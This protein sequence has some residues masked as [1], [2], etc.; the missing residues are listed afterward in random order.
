METATSTA[1]AALVVA[2]LAMFVAMVQALQ[3]YYVTGH[4]IRLCDSVVFGKMPGRGKRVWEMSQLR[5]RI[6]YSMPQ[7]SLHAHLWPDIA[8]HIPSYAKGTEPLPDLRMVDREDA[9]HSKERSY[10]TAVPGEAS[11]VSFCR[12]VQNSCGR[13]MVLEL[14]QGDADRC[15]SDLPNVP[16]PMSMRDIAAM[17]LMAGMKCT[18]ASFESKSLSMQGAIGTITTSQHPLLGPILHFAPRNLSGKAPRD[19]RLSDGAISPSWMART[20]GDAVVAG[21]H[22]SLSERRQVE[23]DEAAWLRRLRDM[24]VIPVNRH[25]S[26]PP[27]LIM[28][29][30]RR[31]FRRTKS[32]TGS[33]DQNS[34]TNPVPTSQAAKKSYCN[35][36]TT[37]WAHSDG[38]WYFENSPRDVTQHP[39]S[40]SDQV[41]QHFQSTQTASSSREAAYMDSLT[42]PFT[43][44]FRRRRKRNHVAT[45]DPFGIEIEGGRRQSEKTEIAHE[46][47]SQS[48]GKENLATSRTFTSG[49]VQ[50]APVPHGGLGLDRQPRWFIREYV[51]EKRQVRAERGNAENRGKRPLLIKWH[52]G[53]D[54]E[55]PDFNGA[56]VGVTQAVLDM[57]PRPTRQ[58]GEQRA[59]FYAHKWRQIVKQRQFQRQ[60]R[61]GSWMLSRRQRRTTHHQLE[62]GGRRTSPKSVPSG[63]NGLIQHHSRVRTRPTREYRSSSYQSFDSNSSGYRRHRHNLPTQTESRPHSLNTRNEHSPIRALNSRNTKQI[64]KENKHLHTDVM[65]NKHGDTDKQL[66]EEEADRGKGKQPLDPPYSNNPNQSRSINRLQRGRPDITTFRERIIQQRDPPSKEIPP[67]ARWTKINRRVVSPAALHGRESFEERPEH[68]IVFRVLTKD[69]IQ[70]Y[71]NRTAE[72]RDLRKLTGRHSSLS[73]GVLEETRPRG[74]LHRRWSSPELLGGYRHNLHHQKDLH[75][76]TAP[77]KQ[78]LPGSSSYTGTE[79]RARGRSESGLHDCLP[80]SLKR[81]ASPSGHATSSSA[82]ED[83][84]SQSQSIRD[85]IRRRNGKS[86]PI[87]RFEERDSSISSDSVIETVRSPYIFKPYSI[88]TDEISTDEDI[89]VRSDKEET[90]DSISEN[91]DDETNVEQGAEEQLGGMSWFWACQIDAMPGY[92]ATPWTSRFSI[93]A[94]FGAIAV[95]LEALGILTEYSQPVYLNAGCHPRGLLWMQSGR[96]TFPP[97]GVNSNHQGAII[98]G[99]YSRTMY[100]GFCAPLFPIELLRDYQFQVDRRLLSDATTLRARLSELMALD[101]WLSY[102]GRQPE[103]CEYGHANGISKPVLGV[104]VLLYTMPTLVQR[105]MDSFAYE[106]ANLERTAVD[107]GLQ[108]V[109]DIAKNLLETLG[110][111]VEGLSP[112]E[113]LF[114]LVAMLRAAKMALCIAQGADTSALRGILLNDVQVHLV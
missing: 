69:E 57:W 71:V 55:T 43:T 90:D 66:S 80:T 73:T 111:K 2:I 18:Q 74:T 89:L 29:G 82:I 81:E 58:S 87:R 12:A 106:F 1:I 68:V 112:A 33:P 109:Q 104:G 25:R 54:N 37:L 92:M 19:P 11:W 100:P 83:D 65:S 23:K 9:A 110:W 94:C 44:V 108:F 56:D 34:S 45:D 103:I 6:V 48:P 32:K 101:S 8:P 86:N 97:Y 14:I 102:C 42:K 51:E 16:M 7:V 85:K 114:A 88:E 3:Q 107:G 105:T 59:A 72:I 60:N 17:A 49:Q 35:D 30:L 95:I 39:T 13:S 46:R 15:P 24:A 63:K 78:I 113:K 41:D 98:S 31:R 4:L 64:E 22:Y 27:L 53:Q 67:G 70:L 75:L 76:D 28:R 20:W 47:S 62:S 21:R 77:P 40:E 26:P 84:S 99:R 52:E 10:L 36:C 61:H 91:S 5:F 96:S 79:H 93:P 38:E 50:L